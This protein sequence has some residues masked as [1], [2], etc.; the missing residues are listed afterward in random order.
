MVAIALM[1]IALGLFVLITVA[2]SLR[3]IL[4]EDIWRSALLLG[5]VPLSVAIHYVMFTA[6][7]INL[8]TFSFQ[9]GNLTDQVFSHFITALAAVKVA[10]GIGIILVLYRNFG[11]VDVTKATTLRW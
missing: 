2:S 10:V 1:A 9:H 5:V 3:V 11:D 7:N 6:V 4:I 8:V